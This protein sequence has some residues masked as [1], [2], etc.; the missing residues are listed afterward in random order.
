MGLHTF[1]DT[2]DAR[3]EIYELENKSNERTKE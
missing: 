2:T 3:R 1:S